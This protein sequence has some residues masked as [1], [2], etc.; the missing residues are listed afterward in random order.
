MHFKMFHL[1][2]SAEKFQEIS[3]RKMYLGSRIGF[4]IASGLVCAGAFAANQSAVP[5]MLGTE[6]KIPF[7]FESADITKIISVYA[8]ASGQRFVLDPSVRGKATIL[9][10]GPVSVEEAFSLMSSALATNQFAISE[11]EDT[12][13]I[14]SSRNAQRSLIP[15]LTELPALKPEKMIT[16]IFQL[17]NISAHDVNLRLRILPSKDGEMTPFEPTNKLIV[18][19][20]VSNVHRIAKLISDLDQPISKE[21]KSFVENSPQSNSS[22]TTPVNK[23]KNKE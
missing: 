10:P 7:S 1:K 17:K 6:K 12:M 19:D 22:G 15:T 9:L 18:T 2:V 16:M 3:M 4:L 8:K 14:M 13:V 5:S 20:W 21:T 11:R 23:G